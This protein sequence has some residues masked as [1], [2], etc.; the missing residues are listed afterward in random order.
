VAEVNPTGGDW[1]TRGTWAS[2]HALDAL[3]T[4]HDP[5]ITGVLDLGGRICR[6]P[7]TFELRDGQ[8]W[9]AVAQGAD[10]PARPGDPAAALEPEQV[11]TTVPVV[12]AGLP[13]GRLHGPAAAQDALELVAAQL[14]Q[15]LDQRW[16]DAQLDHSGRPVGIVVLD[17]EATIR[18]VNEGMG[19]LVGG[20]IEHW[21]G[22]PVTELLTAGQAAAASELLA[23]ALNGR[24]RSASIP[25]HLDFGTGTFTFEVQSDTRFDDPDVNG[26]V[27]VVRAPR[28]ADDDHSI[29]GDQM[30][31]LNRLRSGQPSDEVL[32]RVVDL[33]E[34]RNAGGHC[35]VMLLDGSGA[36]LEPTISPRLHPDVVAALSGTRVG[37]LEPGG[38]ASIHFNGPQ[39]WPV[40]EDEPGFARQQPAL[41]THGYRSCWSMPITSMVGNRKLGSL[42]LYRP[43]PGRPAETEAR[44]M[45]M[46]ARLAALAI[47]QETHERSLRHA[48]TH[49]PLTELPNRTLFAERLDDASAHGNLAV[50]FVDL[51]RFKLIND[52]LGH[53]F[54]D[55]LLQAVAG[56][57]A[58]F[59]REPAIVA[60]FGGD[61]FTV[62]LPKVEH[63]HEAVAEAERLLALIAEPYRVRGQTVS[64]RASAG[65]ATA[66]DP[67]SVPL[68]LVRD[69]DAALY[70]AKDRGRGRVEVFDRRLLVAAEQRLA[71]ERQLLDALD[72]GMIEVAF[73]PEVSLADGRVIGVEALAR[74]RTAT[75]DTIPPALFI[76]V[77]EETG[78]IT[79]VFTSVLADSCRAAKQWNASRAV[80]LVVWV[81]LSPL[82][83]G[84]PELVGQVARAIEMSGVDAS[85]L[86][87]EVTERAILSD[88]D[89][90]AERLQSL[91]ALGCHAALDDFGTGYSSLSHLH[92]L[93]VDTVKLDRTFVVRAQRDDRSR[94]IVGGVVR[95]VDDMGLRCVAEGVETRAEL[96]TVS[97]LGC[98]I[99][100][101]FIFSRPKSA[102]DVSRMVNAIKPPFAPR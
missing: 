26:L 11:R 82:Q 95:L 66:T 33:L 73:Q 1:T 9:L 32:E 34:R 12:A 41:R 64:I 102:A 84:S 90:A 98:A 48:A 30:W 57:L 92:D 77:A 4:H 5:T 80:P 14:S 44:V 22:R 96:D 53:E 69:A 47:D 93:P 88:P 89:E 50:L 55:E 49:D 40:L 97:S 101:G 46:A 8:S 74:C 78:L 3:S 29:L 28:D 43:E 56:R 83:L 39:F 19:A 16:H 24:G 71:V 87:F 51:D 20:P 75:R 68:A 45:V 76:P 99:V 17:D 42:D 10:G 31:V 37:P 91:V 54:G 7:L 65:V 63:V 79:R 2:L 18:Y 60:R 100:Q 15:T 35:C 67:P 23:E 25:L 13:V 52:T 59:V 61:E 21:P 27:F 94:A 70:H 36:T 62:L 58:A 86:G 38:G 6:S 85:T 72:A 81:N